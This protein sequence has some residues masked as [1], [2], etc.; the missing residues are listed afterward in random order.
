M[1]KRRCAEGSV[2]LFC[3]FLGAAHGGCV[4]PGVDA[5]AQ[6]P[7]GSPALEFGDTS[8]GGSGG[9]LDAAPS[10]RSS[11]QPVKL[12]SGPVGIDAHSDDADGAVLPEGAAPTCTLT[13]DDQ[14]CSNNEESGGT[15]FV[16]RSLSL[17]P[18]G[19]LH[20]TGLRGNG[21]GSLGP[22]PAGSAGCR[23]WSME[24]SVAPGGF[25]F[26]TFD[27][28]TETFASVGVCPVPQT[29]TYYLVDEVNLRERIFGSAGPTLTPTY[30]PAPPTLE[31]EASGATW[32]TGLGSVLDGGVL[33]RVVTKDKPGSSPGTDLEFF[34]MPVSVCLFSPDTLVSSGCFP[35]PAT[36][37]YTNVPNN[38]DSQFDVA[39]GGTMFT[40]A[41]SPDGHKAYTFFA[42][43]EG[44]QMLV[45]RTWAVPVGPGATGQLVVALDV[46][47][48]V[49]GDSS[50][51]G[52]FGGSLVLS[53]R[54][55][56]NACADG[57]WSSGDGCWVSVQVSMVDG[58]A[59]GALHGRVGP[60]DC[61]GDLGTEV[62]G[63]FDI[64]YTPCP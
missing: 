46:P 62:D 3:W 55:P 1:E 25:L 35:D 52:E 32:R 21:G 7:I 48:S 56:G 60:G 4:S 16:P 34:D 20:L 19:M 24:R 30:Q 36:G 18:D 64:D 43:L 14:L 2:L 8:A 59:V 31:I 9:L 49:V 12:L 28:S 17:L 63:S 13:E 57:C 23:C 39:V 41:M 5:T 40:A 45:V 22:P 11:F 27:P 51:E 47:L 33:K 26:G 6:G 38:I 37:E 44:E 54:I 29:D 15:V 61:S 42:V 53:D 10:N 58:H 50:Q